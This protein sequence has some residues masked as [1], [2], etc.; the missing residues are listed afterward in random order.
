MSKLQIVLLILVAVVFGIIIAT[1]A[2]S[3][4]SATF[5]E[6]SEN[7]GEKYKIVGTL[8]KNVAIQNDP[9]IDANLTIF[10]VINSE[11]KSQVVYLHQDTGRPLGLERSENVTLEGKMSADGIFHSDHLQMKCPSK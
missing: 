9:N 11:G 2:Q 3:T 1:Y 5:G 10:N 6:A 4:N 7:V 8:D